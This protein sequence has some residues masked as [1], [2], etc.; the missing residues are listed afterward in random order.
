M[1]T[2]SFTSDTDWTVPNNVHAVTVDLHGGRGGNGGA[3][4]GRV[5][6]DLAVTPGETVHVRFPSDGGTGGGDG[7]A[8]DAEP[9]GDGGDSVDIRRG[10]T[11]LGDRLAVAAG[12]GGDGGDDH[13]GAGGAG[14]AG[15][16]DTGEDG[17]DVSGGASGG[18]G[19]TQSAGG[20]GGG[21]VDT[22]GGLGSGGDGDGSVVGGGG[23]GGGGLYGGGGGAGGDVGNSGGGGGA[24]GSNYDDDLTAVTTNSR[25]GSQ[26]P[27]GEVIISYALSPTSVAVESTTTT[28]VVVGWDWTGGLDPD[29]FNVYRSDSEPVTSSDTLAGSTTDGTDRSFTD[30]GRDENEAYF[31]AVAASFDGDESEVSATVQGRTLA[32]AVVGLAVADSDAESV[33]LDWDPYGVE[34]GETLVEYRVYRDTSPGVGTGDSLVGTPQSVGFEDMSVAEGT[35]HFYVVTAVLEVDA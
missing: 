7:G 14:G 22:E 21:G 3:D 26:A 15:G 16:A 34:S 19:G 27:G 5:T 1:P 17:G 31:Y 32:E 29:H 12:G 9:G 20:T 18:D 11:S 23:A 8:A 6:G 28:S 33:T 13:E 25:G 35:T 24:G 10:G 30:D 2:E 4:G